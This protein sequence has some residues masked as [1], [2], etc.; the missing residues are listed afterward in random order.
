VCGIVVG[1]GGRSLRPRPELQKWR[2]VS[3]YRLIVFFTQRWTS[4]AQ[5]C[6]DTNGETSCKNV[7]FFSFSAVGTTD[8]FLVKFVCLLCGLQT[9]GS[10]VQDV[11]RHYVIGSLQSATCGVLVSLQFAEAFCLTR[12][13]SKKYTYVIERTFLSQYWL[14]L[15]AYYVQYYRAVCILCTVLYSCLHTMYSIIEL[16]A[17]YVQYYRAVCIL[18]TV[19]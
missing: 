10:R 5:G 7:E 19:L 17:Y 3:I 1:Q 13:I 6:Q 12:N 15:F 2:H 4:C 8:D 18:C 11:G 9:R 14:E 16:F